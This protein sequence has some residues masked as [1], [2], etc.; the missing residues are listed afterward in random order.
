LRLNSK[1]PVR[2][3][4][5]LH[6]REHPIR[7]ERPAPFECTQRG[8]RDVLNVDKSYLCEQLLRLQAEG[9]V[10][11][12]VRAIERDRRRCGRKVG[13]YSLTL[14]GRKLADMIVL[15]QTQPST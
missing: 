15:Q 6:L 5:V 9:I 2:E 13:A 10:E 7:D 4:I 3:K 12:Q 11:V 14:K 8:M 1:R